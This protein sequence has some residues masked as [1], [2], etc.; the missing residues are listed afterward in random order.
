M[1]MFQRHGCVS[2]SS[3]SS[4]VR[5]S[6]ECV[7]IYVYRYEVFE[8]DP[9]KYDWYERAIAAALRDLEHRNDTND[10]I[11]TVAVVGAGRGPLV[12]RALRASQKTGIK[13]E[14]V[15]SIA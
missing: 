7:L 10:E 14:Y 11:L 12:T 2:G 13:I 8:K 4:Y 15:P 1:G 3:F 6:G 9:V 5:C